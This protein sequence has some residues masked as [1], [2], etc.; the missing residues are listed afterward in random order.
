VLLEQFLRVPDRG[1]LE[2]LKG[3]HDI[4]DYRHVALRFSALRSTLRIQ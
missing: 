1:R 4:P 3:R 2:Q